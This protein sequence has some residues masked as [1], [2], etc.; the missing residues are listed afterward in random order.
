MSGAGECLACGGAIWCCTV[1]WIIK[2]G[3]KEEQEKND[4]ER[5]ES[6]REIEAQLEQQEKDRKAQE[7]LREKLAQRPTLINST[8]P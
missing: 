1:G 4:R 2:K 3:M 5:A 6:M 7:E 8:R